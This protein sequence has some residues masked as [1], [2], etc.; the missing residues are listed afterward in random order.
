[1][2]E[3]VKTDDRNSDSI[4]HHAAAPDVSLGALARLSAPIFV[5]NL[6]IMGA[7]T[8]DTLMTGN[9]GKEHLAAPPP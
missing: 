5:A 1:M 4:P 3:N 8:I 2:S 9:L 7:A 6:A